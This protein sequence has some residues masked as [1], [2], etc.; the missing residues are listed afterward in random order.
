MEKTPETNASAGE[1][2]QK[3]YRQLEQR[4]AQLQM[5]LEPLEAKVKW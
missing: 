3:H 2:Q 4:N 1:A 5:Q